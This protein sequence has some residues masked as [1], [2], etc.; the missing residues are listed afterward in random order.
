MNNTLRN[1]IL[2]I[3]SFLFV[4]HHSFGDEQQLANTRFIYLGIEDGLSNNS[5]TSIYQDEKGFIW[6]GTFDGLNRFD[7]YDFRLF[8]NQPG[9]K[10]TLIHNRVVS[11][12]GVDDEVWVGTKRG[13][14]VFDYETGKF[15]KA[16]YAD[17]VSGELDTLAYP[18]NE[19]YKHGG[20]IFV[21]TAGRGLLVRDGK[22]GFCKKIELPGG[23]D[24]WNYHVQG[25]DSASNGE[26][27]LFVQGI[28]ITKLDD[29]NQQL[30]IVYT[31]I[32]SGRCV[33][34]D[35]EGNFWVGLDNGLLKYNL[36]DRTSYVFSQEDV[37]Y[38]FSDILYLKDRQ[39]I[40]AAT[41]GNGIVGYDLNVKKFFSI[42]KKSTDNKLSSNSIYSMLQDQ[43]QRIW[44]GTVRG[45]IN[46]LENQNNLFQ[47]IEANERVKGET[48]PSNF[49]QAFCEY[50]NNQVWI[51]TD[52]NGVS[53]W[54]INNNKFVNFK[55][56]DDN[57][58]SLPGNFVTSIKKG[59]GGY[60]FATYGGGISRFDEKS[61]GFIRYDL[62]DGVHNIYHRN[63]WVLFVDSQKN[64]WACSSDRNGMFKYNQSADIFEFIDLRLN[65][66]LAVAEDALHNMW[67]GTFN[68]LVRFNPQTGKQEDIKMDCPVRAILPINKN[69]ILV[70]TE[71]GGLMEYDPLS[72]EKK[73]FIVQDG[74]C[75]NSVLNI[76][77]D[78]Y[79]Y[80]W[81]SSYNGIS[82]FDL[83]T[84]KFTNYYDSDGLQ[85][86]Q[87]SYNAGLKLSNGKILFG[88]IKGFNI[89][90]PGVTPPQTP[91]PDLQIT[92]IKVNNF[93][94]ERSGM[95]ASMIE[96]LELPSDRSMLTISYVGI[97]YSHPD[98]ISYA[99]FL[100]GWD[101]G[102]HYV[103][104][105]RAA[106]YS[107]LREGDYVFKIKSTNAEGNWNEHFFEL[108]IL[109]TPPWYRSNLAYFF[110]FVFVIAIVWL[111]H[112]YRKNQNML[113]YEIQLST[114][115]IKQEKDLSEKKLN[116]F[117][118]VSYEFRLPLT[119]IINP[120]KDMLYGGKIEPGAL[121]VAYRSSR[122]L[123]NMVD[124]LLM[125]RKIE[126]ERTQM[127][128]QKF[129]IVELSKDVYSSFITQ[130]KSKGIDYRVTVS[131]D[132]AFIYGDRQ[133]L[134]ICL[135]NLLINAFK[136]TDLKGGR[137]AL[138]V[139]KDIE[140]NE[141][142][143]QVSD[144]GIGV[145]DNEK[146][147]IFDLFYQSSEL[148]SRN[149]EKGFGIGLYIVDMYVQ[150]H[151]GS[152]KCIDNGTGGSIFEIRLK[153]G[154][155]HFRE[156]E[157]SQEDQD[158]SVLHYSG[159]EGEDH[160]PPIFIDDIENEETDGLLAG[161]TIQS[162]ILVDKRYILIVD[163]DQPTIHYM[164]KILVDQC[165]VQDAR[166]ATEA[167]EMIKKYQPDLIISDV[168]LDD[169]SGIDFCKTIKTAPETQHI[170]VI[171][172]SAAV[173]E[174]IKLKGIEEGADDYL[175]KPF[176]PDYLKAKINGIFKRQ[177]IL[178]G[179]LLNL[180]TLNSSDLKLSDQE[181]EFLDQ[182]VEFI[183]S[184]P[185][186][187]NMTKLANNLGVS[188]SLL[189]K[190]VKQLTGKTTVEFA[191]FVRLRM[192][193]M[194]LI[195]S[196]TQ[197]YEAA[198]SCGFNDQKYFRKHFQD[199]YQM[200]PSVFRKKYKNSLQ[201][202]Q[203][204]IKDN[205]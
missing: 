30:E 94:L 168:L 71:G 68:E 192:V 42:D 161:N 178:Q 22:N 111:I 41:D 20:K 43:E 47:T 117:T 143:I 51:G 173:S 36:N 44:L 61:N 116:F 126:S 110:Y 144:N 3:L 25:I 76:I 99:Y 92:E 191:R 159:V 148:K 194:K 98:K 133:K 50:E 165:V 137:V 128:I 84:E 26:L 88:G 113:K 5:V 19:V 58:N 104:S 9:D 189:Y 7:G 123:L 27:W 21:G 136:F 134:E 82:K 132:Q 32:K 78:D 183:E 74:L 52:G 177:E 73:V 15:S 156:H 160:G 101:M 203:Y 29:K 114:E 158:E 80:Y 86:N 139:K 102:W 187:F 72:K 38:Q 66:I 140:N 122:R 181:K 112:T 97:E 93:P 96:K 138:N 33:T 169:V 171:L 12:S 10:S 186:G 28:G 11:V 79:G 201:D 60:W 107:K 77:A 45:G 1:F 18:V 46:L 152:I 149:L 103:G 40:W 204:I 129:D 100:D 147:L 150:Q 170:P 184:D 108:P 163:N 54:D 120:L 180:V 164:K 196:D 124:Q 4:V 23:D 37:R 162:E 199:Q 154:K 55:H 89:V 69:M 83:S 193:A 115:K 14:S 131:I 197:I 62:Y 31:G 24:R 109:I 157:I 127:N 190:R 63:I 151:H 8:R 64:L 205:L 172:L 53:L 135:Y 2:L 75:N 202:K 182:V 145:R 175:T 174:E 125:F 167:L 48:L 166:N 118:A 34:F 81:M 90:D 155:E 146:L 130:A 121:S 119:V 185:E 6:I 198:V 39:Q 35:D 87:F 142:V 70:G 56:Q 85:S 13:L 153:E 188:Q 106:N 200:S 59:P 65:G 17:P 179:R 16:F 95:S 49:V 195:A 67:I 176:D 57:P 91:F 105:S 141:L